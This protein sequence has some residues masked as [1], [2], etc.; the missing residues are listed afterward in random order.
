MNYKVKVNDKVK[1]IT[2]KDKGKIGKVLRLLKDKK[3]IVVEGINMIKRHSKPTSAKNSQGGIIEK[4][5]PFDISNVMLV[6]NSCVKPTRVKMHILEDG[7]RVR[8]C[9]KC[10]EFID[11]K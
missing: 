3:K 9:Q 2:G 1:V 4:E 11:T 6:C 7:K 10:N 8:K 5:A